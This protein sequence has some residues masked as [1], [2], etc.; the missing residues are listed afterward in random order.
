MHKASGLGCSIMSRRAKSKSKPLS[1]H[2]IHVSK[3]MN[4]PL[5]FVYE[6][7][8]DYREDD[9]KITGSATQRRIL[10]KTKDRVIYVSTYKSGGKLK[11]AVNIVS[12]HPMRS[13][14]LEFVGEEDDELG[15]YRLVKLGP[16]RTRLDMVFKEK[17]KIRNAPSKAEDLR[18]T[19]ELWGKYVAAL[20]RDYRRG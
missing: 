1:R 10:Q 4:A 6:W 11:Y 19:N 12:L 9:N 2:T 15:D 16:E 14:H 7:C 8:T 18:H 20:E 3:I 13:W 17:Y 5:S